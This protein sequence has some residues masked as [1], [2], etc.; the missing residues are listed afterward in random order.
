MSSIR[1]IFV[2]AAFGADF[3][4]VGPRTLRLARAAARGANEV[5]QEQPPPLELLLVGCELR[6]AGV[7]NCGGAIA[8]S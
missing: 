1:S 7:A 5:A 8:I 4:L 6:I 2:L 3:S